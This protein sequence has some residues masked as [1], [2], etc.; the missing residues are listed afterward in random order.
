M[1][2]E[3]SLDNWGQG[4]IPPRQGHGTAGRSGSGVSEFNLR[5]VQETVLRPAGIFL[6]STKLTTKDTVVDLIAVGINEQRYS[7][8]FDCGWDHLLRWLI[9]WRQIGGAGLALF[10]RY[11]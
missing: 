7:D 9:H 8:R 1:A 4:E 5:G 11:T 10:D 2:S 6:Q 3:R